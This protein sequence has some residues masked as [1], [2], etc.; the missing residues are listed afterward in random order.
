MK[1]IFVNR[2]YAPDHSATSQMLTDLAV[3]LAG[4][5]TNVHIV[6]S[7]LR[8]D[9]PTAALPPFEVID[10][11]SVH[12]VPTTRFG[13]GKLVGRAFDYLSFYFGA[14]GALYRLAR[15]GDIVV[16]K[17]DPPLI[18]VPAGWVARLRGAR[19]VNWLQ[20][21]FPEVALELGV[22][23]GKGA[24]S[25]L[26]AWLRDRSLKS[27][28][29]NVVLGR[30]MRDRLTAR[31]IDPGKIAVIPNWADGAVLRPVGARENALRANWGLTDKF[32]VGYS[33][34][35]GRAHE[36]QTILDAAGTLRKRPEIVFAFIGGGA[37]E[38]RIAD[39]AGTANSNIVRKPYQPRE[40]LAE[41][42]SAADVHL[43][44]LRPRLE[45][46]IVPSKFYGIIA[47]ARP[48]I[49]I[50]DPEGELGEV[51]R[52][53]E[54][55]FVVREGDVAGLVGAIEALLGDPALRETMGR[56]ARRVF[57][58]RYDMGIAVLSWRRLLADVAR[59]SGQRA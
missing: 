36:F 31:R 38:S 13:R 7:R 58:E 30:V 6:T 50:G 16:A 28:S 53:R 32:V 26:L 20:D 3:A 56:N 39:A 42:L 52:S 22:D 1:V 19:L 5:G 25:G 10:G 54:C 18:S 59:E 37:Q 8:Y 12:R 27:A 24:W 11:V 49:F 48:T 57:D 45:G 2:F 23:A 43:V 41:C 35:M 9:D 33:G 29:R 46:L 14:S 51:I 55:G 21:L 34:N 47:V 4:G 17:T 15:E 44:S 40:V